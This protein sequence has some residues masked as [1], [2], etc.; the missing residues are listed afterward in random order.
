MYVLS[1]KAQNELAFFNSGWRLF[2]II[3]L[4]TANLLFVSSLVSP[5]LFI[6]AG[7]VTCN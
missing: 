2:E 6:F 7:N 3:S 1:L 5:V 4:L